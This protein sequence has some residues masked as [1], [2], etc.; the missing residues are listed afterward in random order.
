MYGFLNVLKP[1]G[2]TSHDVVL[3][4]RRIFSQKRAGHLGTL[5]P[6]AQGVLPVALGSYTRL[7]EYLLD[8]DKEYLAEFTFGISTDTCDLDGG[9]ISK[10]P[11]PHLEASK[12]VSLLP[13][14]T[15]VIR[16]IPPAYSAVQV[17]GQRLH[18]L[19]R[20]GIPVKPPERK[21]NVHEFRLLH[22]RRGPY[23]KGVFSLRVGRGTYV[24][25]LATD[26]GAELGCGATVSYLLRTRVGRF[27]LKDALLMSSLQNRLLKFQ[28]EDVLLSPYNVFADFPLFE[29]KPD[30]ISCVIHGKPLDPSAFQEPES[31]EAWL[32][33]PRKNDCGKKDILVGVYSDSSAQRQDIAC[34]LSVAMDE[35]KSYRIKYEKVLIRE[36]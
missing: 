14:Y 5:D 1:K 4:V 8:Q 35:D 29:L 23:P 13:K 19:A 30:A 33:R 2:V 20:Q 26:L 15:G 18:K 10:K 25:T 9:I 32:N 17:K 28:L 12:V 16:Q 31:I 27:M 6:M 7:S 24:R 21:V 36:E 22:W 11:C 34:V 3:E